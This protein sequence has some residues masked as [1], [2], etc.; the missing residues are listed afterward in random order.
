MKKLFFLLAMALMAVPSL[1]LMSCGDDDET[2]V[3]RDYANGDDANGDDANGDDA[4]GDDQDAGD[5]DNSESSRT[6]CRYCHGSGDCPGSNCNNGNCSRCGG[7]GY[8]YT[9]KYKS[10]CLWCERGKCP[11]CN[12]R[13]R[14]PKCNGTGYM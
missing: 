13:A 9:G 12:G 8:T 6:E 2:E 5:D 11:V 4:N 1:S 7:K 3:V 10:P 14:C